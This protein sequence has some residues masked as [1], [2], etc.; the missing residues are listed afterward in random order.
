MKKKQKLRPTATMKRLV[1][2]ALLTLTWAQ[3]A[4]GQHTVESIR[5]QYTNIKANITEMLKEEGYPDEYYQVLVRQ[6]LPATGGHFEDTRMYWGER[7]DD[8]IY[9]SHYVQ[10]V[11]TKYNFA[12]REFY[13]EYLYDEKG[14][15][16]FIYAQTP[17][18][19]EDMDK[20]HE[21]RFYFDAGK[22]IKVLVKVRR[23]ADSQAPFA[24]EYSGTTVPEKY[25]NLYEHY[26]GWSRQFVQLFDAVDGA[27]HL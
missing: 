5:K 13:E 9:P 17:D 20:M 4:F 12:V 2:I 14:N 6:N 27:A 7:D 1:L 10:F 3:T 21:L 16:L 19:D 8:E 24:E 25:K 23:A 26:C 22:L 11:T 15:I 18:A